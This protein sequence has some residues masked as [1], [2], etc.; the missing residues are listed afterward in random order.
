MK[1]SKTFAAGALVL[2]ALSLAGCAAAPAAPAPAE[3]A[4]SSIRDFGPMDPAC[5]AAGEPG[6]AQAL[7]S[8]VIPGAHGTDALPGQARTA[9]VLGAGADLY[10]QTEPGQFAATGFQLP[11]AMPWAAEVAV[12]AVVTS[13]HSC[14]LVEVLVP[15]QSDDASVRSA[16]AWVPSEQVAP[17]SEWEV[18]RIISVDISDAS[19]SVTEG[20]AELLAIDGLVT[21]GD[22]ATPT[23][24]GYVVSE[25][26]DAEQQP[27]TGG[28]SITL[29]SL[30]ADTSFS[31]N[32]GEIGVHW[33][34][35]AADDGSGSN[36]CVRVGDLDQVR[37]LESVVSPG[38]I[39]IITE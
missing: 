38:D 34:D 5:I 17:V 2:A 8:A 32:S 4:A 12:P 14:G 25:Y 18:P 9:A 35:P 37:A 36:G 7:T 39:V 16:S 22:V 20:D 33:M 3:A 21:G 13:T 23:G 6:T 29:T 27:W 30:H 11:A 10:V 19:L 26:E 28:E 31:G 15:S 1:T 24:L